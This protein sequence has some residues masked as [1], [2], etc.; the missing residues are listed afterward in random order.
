MGTEVNQQFPENRWTISER[1]DQLKNVT[2]LQDRAALQ[3]QAKA[4]NTYKKQMEKIKKLIKENENLRKTLDVNVKGDDLRRRTTMRKNNAYKLAYQYKPT[5]YIIE[6][7]SSVIFNKK[8]KLDLLRYEK[9][10][11]EKTLFT[12]KDQLMESKAANKFLKKLWKEQVVLNKI[13][14]ITVKQD[15]AITVKKTY[16]N[17]IKI[18]KEDAQSFDEILINLK[19]DRLI[20]SKC[21]LKATE[22]GQNASED[23]ANL[24]DEYKTQE[25]NILSLMRKMDITAKNIK[26]DLEQV[27]ANCKF[28]IR[29]ESVT[30]FGSAQH[31]D[32]D[33]DDGQHEEALAEAKVNSDLSE[34]EESL[35]KIKVATEVLTIDEVYPRIEHQVYMKIKILKQLNLKTTLRNRLLDHRNQ[36][37]SLLENLQHTMLSTTDWF[38]EEKARLI[39]EAEKTEKQC[40]ETKKAIEKTGELLL[41]IRWALLSLSRKLDRVDTASNFKILLSDLEDCSPQGVLATLPPPEV[42]P[43]EIQEK[44]NKKLVMLV[45]KIRTTDF[46]LNNTD[47]LQ[48][49]HEFDDKIINENVVKQKEDL[50]ELAMTEMLEELSTTEDPLVPT[51]SA[52]KNQSLKIVEILGAEH[53]ELTKP[54]ARTYKT[55][56]RKKRT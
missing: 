7:I 1:I 33:D 40:S 10:E 53:P 52:I 5:E 15:A 43:S 25:V 56:R 11:M 34:L 28:V 37:E 14:N 24:Y 2:K 38:R 32:D 36:L 47:Y 8:K 23:V 30:R 12:L 55:S 50:Y 3:C 29:T 4:I 39:S 46:T 21:I 18:L 41:G 51:R 9:R 13:Q 42:D 54:K 16:E 31:D 49:K 17:M 45:S 44:I 35:Q 26:A 27:T 6:N 19:S 20:Q 22:M 48:S